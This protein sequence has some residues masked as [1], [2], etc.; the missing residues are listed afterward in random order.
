ESDP[1]ISLEKLKLLAK[2]D[3]RIVIG[4]ATSAEVGAVKNFA[5]K[6]DIKSLTFSNT[7]LGNCDKVKEDVLPWLTLP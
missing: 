5:D 7:E 1:A 3:I 4:P 6:N 2:N